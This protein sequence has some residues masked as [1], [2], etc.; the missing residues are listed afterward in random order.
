MER[1]S[2][3]SGMR[4]MPKRTD[5]A[6]HERT[7]Y[8]EGYGDNILVTTVDNT[9][10]QLAQVVIQADDARELVSILGSKLNES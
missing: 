7:T 4:D 8:A 2:I 6:D 1:G 10:R 9:G 3:E 5:L